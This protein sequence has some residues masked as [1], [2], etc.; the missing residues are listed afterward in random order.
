MRALRLLCLAAVTC[1]IARVSVADETTPTSDDSS[2]RKSGSGDSEHELS[3]SIAPPTSVTSPGTSPTTAPPSVR[4]DS[5]GES[6]NNEREAKKNPS[7]DWQKDPRP[8]IVFIM[9]DDMGFND[10]PWNEKFM[11]EGVRNHILAPRMDELAKKGIIFDQGYSLPKCTPSRAATMTGRY[12]LRFGLHRANVNWA[13]PYGLPLTETLMPA[14]MKR[15]GYRT[16]YVGKWHLGECNVSYVPT[17]RGYDSFFGSYVGA[18]NYFSHSKRDSNGRSFGVLHNGTRPT[19]Q[20]YNMHATDMFAK[21]ASDVIREHASGEDTRT[22]PLFLNVFFNAP[23]SPITPGKYGVPFYKLPKSTVSSRRKGY[24]GLV[25]SLDYGVHTIVNSL[26]EAG[27]WDNTLLVFTSDNGGF[28]GTGLNYPLRGGKGKYY[29]GG[30][31][32]P[33]FAYHSG[34]HNVSGYR[35]DTLVHAVDWLP[36]FATLGGAEKRDLPRRL[37]GIDF[38]HVLKS[39]IDLKTS[40]RQTML[41]GALLKTRNR[42]DGR[43]TI[44]SAVGAY[45][46]RYWKIVLED[47]R[48]PIRDEWYIGT[49]PSPPPTRGNTSNSH[50]LTWFSRTRS[51]WGLFNLKT[52]PFEENN[53]IRQ[54]SGVFYELRRRLLRYVDEGVTPLSEVYPMQPEAANRHKALHNFYTHGWC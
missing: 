25:L 7:Q 4:S 41:Y 26:K 21:V 35:S 31:R 23:H 42:R 46:A 53:I 44:S 18:L 30:V 9:A 19:T 17:S 48:N 40:P 50:L 37:D 45:R 38:S 13:S 24:M 36:T 27:I 3:N 10:V 2:S 51:N 6:E 32:M 52:D 22:K 20:Y 5:N 15:L 16:H 12:P 54:H 28:P 1:A 34:W 43:G 11:P 33:M 8:N 14:V 47:S 39:P 49:D 29:E